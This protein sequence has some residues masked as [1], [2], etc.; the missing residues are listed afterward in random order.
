MAENTEGRKKGR[1][2]ECPKF[3]G[4][5]GKFQEWKAKVEMWMKLEED[6]IKFPGLEIKMSLE[7]EAFKTV[8]DVEIEKLVKK[9]GEKVIMER[10]EKRYGKDKLM[11]SF[12]K[13]TNFFEIKRGEEETMQEYGERFKRL[14]RECEIGGGG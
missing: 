4:N 3:G 2:M 14:Q 5:I 12:E 13:M 7:G 8:D 10:L 1:V 9:G 11:D 6:T